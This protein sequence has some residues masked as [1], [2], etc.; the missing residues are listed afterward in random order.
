MY[1]SIDLFAG[2]G[3]IRLGFEQAFGNKLKTVYVSEIDSNAVKTY[4]SNFSSNKLIHGDVTKEVESD[5]PPHDFLLAGFPCHAFSAA[6]RQMGFDDAR[7]T[8]FFEVARIINYHKPQVVFAENVKNLV[9]HDKG[10]TFKVI[11]SALKN[12][13]YQ[14]FHQVLNSKNFG[15]PQ[16]RKRI[17]I[18][19]F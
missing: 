16:N 11:V 7:G 2:I 1:S 4:T 17:Y 9:N 19:A 13:G 12:L 5:I 18:V 14:V 10:E 15:V 3:C 6:G 8:L